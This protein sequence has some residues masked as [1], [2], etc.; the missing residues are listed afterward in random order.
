MSHYTI[1]QVTKKEITFDQLTEQFATD[2]MK[3]FVKN[4]QAEGL[5]LESP[6]WVFDK[7]S[8]NA[9]IDVPKLLRSGCNTVSFR[10]SVIKYII[11]N[12]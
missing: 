12:Y 3:Q 4:E 11:R 10:V 7:L 5:T 6:L 1:Q 8:F 2:R 9:P